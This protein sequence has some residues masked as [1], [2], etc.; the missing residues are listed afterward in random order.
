MAPTKE[1][2]I[3]IIAKELAKTEANKIMDFGTAGH[4][5]GMT[6]REGEARAMAMTFVEMLTGKKFTGNLPENQ[7]AWEK[8][9]HKLV[10]EIESGAL[11]IA[12][13]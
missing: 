7:E 11:E 13:K 10:N 4:A 2:A 1:Q 12:G 3:Q 5:F 9:N 6:K 8:E